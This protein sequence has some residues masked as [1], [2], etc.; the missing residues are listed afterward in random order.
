[1]KVESAHLDIEEHQPRAFVDLFGSGHMDLFN[2]DWDERHKDYFDYSS[3]LSFLKGQI[4]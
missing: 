4:E 1:L 2:K 3:A